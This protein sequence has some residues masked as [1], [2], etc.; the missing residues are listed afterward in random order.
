MRTGKDERVKSC[1]KWILSSRE[2]GL[3]LCSPA[4]VLFGWGRG[5]VEGA[6]CG[7]GVH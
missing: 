6:Q 3:S 2:R 5:K 1:S 7:G 4:C